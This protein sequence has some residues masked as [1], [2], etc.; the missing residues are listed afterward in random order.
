MTVASRRRLVHSV[1]A[2]TA[3]TSLEAGPRERA[4]LDDFVQGLRTI[5]QVSAALEREPDGEGG[6]H[7]QL[8]LNRDGAPGALH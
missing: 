5:E 6:A 8:A 1:L 3:G 7:A 4:L 2:F